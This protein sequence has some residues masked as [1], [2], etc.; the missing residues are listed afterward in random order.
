MFLSE[1]YSIKLCKKSSINVK[2]YDEFPKM[3]PNIS[4][5]YTDLQCATK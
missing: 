3:T 5:L 1:E 4:V 2:D